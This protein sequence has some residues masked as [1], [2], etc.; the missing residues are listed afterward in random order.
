LK[1]S[2]TTKKKDCFYLRVCETYLLEETSQI[3]FFVEKL[4][5]LW[6]IENGVKNILL[7]NKFDYEDYPENQFCVVEQRQNSFSKSQTFFFGWDQ[8]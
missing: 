4:F 8:I 7:E 1:Y 5:H 3:N 2:Q 6:F